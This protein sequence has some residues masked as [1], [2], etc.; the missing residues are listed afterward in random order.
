MEDLEDCHYKPGKVPAPNR[1]TWTG[2]ASH[3]SAKNF[4]TLRVIWS[5]SD[6]TRLDELTIQNIGLRDE[7]S[8][9]DRWLDEFP[10]RARS[11]ATS[12]VWKNIGSA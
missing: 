6:V 3:L 1:V 8:K 12:H 7:F 10:P 2:G 5:P 4:L 11:K 9:A